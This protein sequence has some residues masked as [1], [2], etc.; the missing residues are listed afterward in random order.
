MSQPPRNR[1]AMALFTLNFFKFGQIHM[2][3]CEK[4][5]MGPSQGSVLWK[6]ILT[7]VWNGPDPVLAWAWG[8]VCVFPHTHQDPIWVPE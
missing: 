1:I 7:G 5:F 8:A 6:D 4:T 3:T 2:L